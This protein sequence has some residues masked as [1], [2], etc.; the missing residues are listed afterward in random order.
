M[1]RFFLGI[2]ILISLSAPASGA[3]IKGGFFTYRYLGPGSSPGTLKYNI[4]LTVYMICNPSAGQLS[5]PINFSIFD[6]GNNQF[7]RDVSV[8]ISSQ[9]TLTKVYDEPCITGNETGCYYTIVVYNLASVDLPAT[10]NG[11]IVAYQRCCRI[12]GINNIVNSGNVGNTFS[13][14]IPGT[15]SGPGA[16]TNSSPVFQV[17]D[18][19][20]VCRKS[21]F[22]FSFQASD[23]DGDS[24][25]YA[26][27]NAYQGGDQN[28]P[29]PLTAENPPYQSVPY[30]F[31]YSGAQPMGSG[32]SID[33]ETGIISGV[34]PDLLGEFVVGVCVN[35]FRNGVVIGRSEKEL[36]I[37]V[38]D[39]Q[40]LQ[41]K[42][43]PSVITCDGYT[44]NFQNLVGNQAG[45]EYLWTFGNPASGNA[46]TSVLAT[47]THTY[48]DTGIYIVKLKVSLASGL[49]ADST[50]M[51]AKVY[52]GFFPG[53]T[54]TGG[55]YTNPINFID[56]TTTTYGT[57][58]TWSWNFGD[59][60]TM[61]DTSHLQNPQWTYPGPGTADVSFIVTNSKGC[62]DTV[63]QTVVLFDKPLLTL[64][65]NDTLICRN[66][67][68]QLVANGTGNFTWT[69][70]VNISNPT[71]ANPTVN[72]AVTTWY[73]VS[74]DNNSCINNDSVRV[75]V[76]NTVSLNAINDTTICQ[77][78]II[79]LGAITDGLTY[80]W[81]PAANL[82]DPTLLNPLATTNSTTT[83]QIVSTIGSCSSTDNVT[84]TTVPYPV[85]SLGPD[86]A[87]CYNTSAQLNGTIN[88][89]SFSWTPASYLNNPGILNPVTSP[90]RTTQYILSVFDTL[91]CP[92]P[93]TDTVTIT[94]NPKV[95]AFAGNDTTVVINQ[96]LQ[97]SGSGGVNYSWT[98]ATHLS[99][100]TISNPVGIYGINDDSITYKLVVTDAIGCSDSAYVTVRVFKTN[101]YIFVPSAFTPNDDGLNDVF[102]PIAVGIQKINYFSVYNRWGQLVFTTTING[103]GWDGKI[104]G[105]LQGTGVFV[106]MASGIDY[107]GQPFFQKGTVTLIR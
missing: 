52:P 57:V 24:L 21:Y 12:A 62:I 42:L 103:R 85:A 76:V 6:A 105:Q 45:A 38:N 73:Y 19:V 7:V 101:P 28:S 39:C 18:T 20:V 88:G 33:P 3:H 26:F 69:P 5:N 94:V 71:T 16:E 8:N 89:S 86:Q 107:L 43:D 100:T 84:V 10:P 25:S 4:T 67:A 30:Q 82:D 14:T 78:D 23:P 13:I 66:D 99:N 50:T 29:A 92:K 55:C 47:P 63:Q 104:K 90:P 9:Y 2:I 95:K 87:I 41:A 93:G 31:P 56:T 27:C 34:S 59:A 106:W 51:I 11:Y 32:V 70:V 53:F 22:Q 102:K 60:G 36:H 79:Q 15:A 44:L 91:G 96:P 81:T 49:C 35:E 68:V 58:N 65:F 74:L 1:K 17:N 46:D 48:T 75:R 54:Y 64:D 83:Y 61:A 97:F 40:P 98:P 80:S 72:P 37:R 77:G